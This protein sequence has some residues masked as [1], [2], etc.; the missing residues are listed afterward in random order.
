MIIKWF[1]DA[2][3]LP[4]TREHFELYRIIH[5][6][7]F[8]KFGFFPDL[9]N[10]R[11]FNDRMQWLR[12]FDQDEKIIQC[13]D[14]ILVREHIKERV[15]EEYLVKLYQTHNRFEEIDF[16]VL[17]DSFVIKA[18]HDSGTV[19]PVW[20]KDKLDMKAAKKRINTALSKPFGWQE[21]EW[22]YSFIEPKVLVEEFI[23]PENL[24]LPEDYKF[25]CVEGKVKL[26]HYIYDRGSE[27]KEQVIDRA[28][29]PIDAYIYP[30]FKL[31][32]KFTKPAKWNELIRVAE[33]ISNGFKFVRVDLYLSKEK[34][35]AGEMTF[36]PMGGAYRGEGQKIIGQHL[37]FNRTTFKAPVYKRL[38]RYKGKN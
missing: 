31:G 10:C 24:I 28:G 7:F 1:A 29:K 30:S 17:P 3:Y 20:K 12:L 14:K 8:H 26:M 11:D 13:S 9:I 2:R 37:D 18:N 23:D 22:A 6:R 27:P 32:N 34:I 19:I 21:G 5:K 36:W 15:G 25:Y 35:F 33:E 38:K 16:T 4:L